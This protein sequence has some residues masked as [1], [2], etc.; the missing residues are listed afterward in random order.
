M[1]VHMT[2]LIA[3]IQRDLL[4]FKRNP[5]VIAVSVVMPLIYLVILGNAFQG[6]LTKLPMAVVDLDP[7]PSSRRL[8]ENLR[9]LE[10]G[11]KTF[12]IT[13]MKDQKEAI[14]A[15]RD[16][17]FKAALIIPREFSRHMVVSDKAEIGLFVDNTDSISAESVRG[18]VEG[19]LRSIREEYVPIREK[20]NAAYLRGIDLYG[21]VDYDQSLI[22]GVIIMAIFLS[23]MTT[24]VFNLVMDRFMGTDESY[25]LSPVT[26]SDIVTGLIIS[27]L[28]IT[29]ILA[30]LV[31]G[32]SILVTGASFKGGL[33]QYLSIF[34]VIIL[35]SA[36]L[37]GMMFIL[38][39]RANH[40]RIVGVFSGFLNVIFYFPSGAIYPI[41][42]F[43]P[44]LKAF[45]KVNPETYAVDAL[46]S[47]IF[48]N[49]GISAI[50]GDIAFLAIFA[51]I[52]MTMAI[53][54]FKRTL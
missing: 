6:K 8:M 5:V 1:I 22:P 17:E 10:T 45:A 31:F 28:F 33:E 35:T 12:T 51:A 15:V 9:A 44:W 38:L 20:G 16:G 46:K 34:L 49:V 40:P 50:S 27:G 43:P 47:L 4:K 25:L 54:T 2:R 24:G 18:A 48:K 3:V 11:A 14:E 36:G 23:T 41:D 42:S 37:L 53:A 19:A 7:G 32:L 39:G 13:T 29:T 26:K 52:T 21:R 30:M